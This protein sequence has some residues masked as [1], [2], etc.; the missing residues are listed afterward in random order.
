MSITEETE[1][2]IYDMYV[3]DNSGIPI[4]AGCTTSDYCMQHAEQHPLHTGFMAAMQSF[5][6]EV[7][8]G[9]LQQLK[10]PNVKLNFKNMGD[11]TLV[12]VN[13]DSVDDDLIQDKLVQ[14]SNLFKEKYENRVEIFRISEELAL[15]FNDDMYKIGLLPKDRL[16]STKHYFV[17]DIG[18]SQEKSTSLISRFKQKFISLTKK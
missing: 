2:S 3:F 17:T 16:Q 10:F 7:F 1:L 14:A 11:F 5:G 8:S 9:N 6:K 4:F 18:E 15:E 13:P 12:M